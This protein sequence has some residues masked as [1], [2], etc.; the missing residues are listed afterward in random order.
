MKTL[1][2]PQSIH[3]GLRLLLVAGSL[4]LLCLIQLSVFSDAAHAS[5]RIEGHVYDAKADR[6]LVYAN[7]IVVGTM[8]GAMT[9][10]DGGFSISP[11][12][13]GTYELQ[14]TF[15]G[16]ETLRETVELKEG[17]TLPDFLLHPHEYG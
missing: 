16:Y 9:M 10:S 3:P 2:L 4:C 8:V 15:V 17:E 13:A 7:V 5:G 11:L 14:V 1:H 12:E 6:A